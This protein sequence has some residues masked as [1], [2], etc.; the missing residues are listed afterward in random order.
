VQAGHRV[1]ARRARAAT[2]T[3]MSEVSRSSSTLVAHSITGTSP[4]RSTRATASSVA[5]A[6]TEAS[7]TSSTASAR[8]HRGLRLLRDEGLQAGLASGSQPPVSIEG[9]AAAVPQRVVGDAVAG[10]PRHVLHDGLA[11]AQHAVDQRRLAD[12][13]AGRP[14]PGPGSGPAS[15]RGRSPSVPTPRSSTA[16]N[17]GPRRSI[18]A[19]SAASPISTPLRYA[20]PRLVVPA[21]A[22]ALS[23]PLLASGHRHLPVSLSSSRT[24]VGRASVTSVVAAASPCSSHR[25]A[26]P[27]AVSPTS[28][29]TRGRR[30]R[31]TRRAVP[32]RAHATGHARRR[33]CESARA[34]P[35]PAG[36]ADVAADLAGR[37][38][39][40]PGRRRPC[41]PSRSTASSGRQRPPVDDA[42]PHAAPAPAIRSS[43]G[44]A[45][46]SNISCLHEEHRAAPDQCRT[47]AARR[48]TRCGWR[49]APPDRSPAAARRCRIVHA[50]ER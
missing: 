37:R 39:C 24:S 11:A 29:S 46:P 44:P 42:P 23:R 13:R 47:A 45:I 48:R 27:A 36:T 40:P 30:R 32:C 3:A 7:T 49:R 16:T 26:A 2:A 9:E 28:T 19:R 18:S 22:T 38:A 20:P 12:V 33:R 35:R 21:L 4:R 31:R 50:E 6:P 43:V 10:H 15:R 8:L 34:R 1:A 41:P 5:V 14:R 25:R 17:S